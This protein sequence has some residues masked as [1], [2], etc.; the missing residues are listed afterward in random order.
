MLCIYQTTAA[1][2]QHFKILFL[3]FVEIYNMGI[4]GSQT[5]QNK[6]SVNKN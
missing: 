5:V 2:T 4:V 3:K 6:L 1:D